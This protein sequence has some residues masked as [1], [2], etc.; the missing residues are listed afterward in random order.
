VNDWTS[1]VARIVVHTCAR[2]GTS[3]YL[4][5]ERC[6]SCWSREYGSA[7]A[8]GTG[9]CVAATRLHVTAD[10]GEPVA[11]ALAELDEGVLVLGHA[12]PGLRPG[13]RIQVHFGP[14]GPDAGAP[15]AP[16]FRRPA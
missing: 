7:A 4:P 16:A 14:S 3:W 15:L 12:E 13:D 1:G 10:G 6:P 8:A 9:M 11:L 2:C 5:H